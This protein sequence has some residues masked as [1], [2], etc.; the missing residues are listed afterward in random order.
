MET[1]MREWRYNYNAFLTSELEA[2]EWSASRSGRF[3]PG[4]HWIGWVGPT[5]A[6]DAVAK[7]KI[8]SH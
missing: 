1:Y 4:T 2:C 6:L 5:V 8:K 7:I 3:R